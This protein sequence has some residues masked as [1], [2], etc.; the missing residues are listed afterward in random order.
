MSKLSLNFKT[1]NCAK[2]VIRFCIFAILISLV[3]GC[4]SAP[5][6]VGVALMELE[7]EDFINQQE[8]VIAN[9][10]IDIRNSS[11]DNRP[12]WTSTT[13]FEQGNSIYFTGTFVRGVD[14]SMTLRLANAEALKS[15]VQSVGTS[16]RA[17]FSM[18]AQG[19][20]DI[21]SGIDRY[22]EDGIATFS[23]NI[24]I[25]GI[26]QAESYYE[27]M[28]DPKNPMKPYYNVW[29]KLEIG[30]SEYLRAKARVLKQLKNDFQNAGETEAKE[31]AQILLNDLKE[32]VSEAI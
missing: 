21:E 1:H 12:D 15:M 17:E 26:R 32:Q 23:N 31:K 19:A 14:Y 20:N 5:K 29:V 9:Q 7:A 8:T 2:P 28:Y 6:K 22:V 3:M 11:T 27:E 30:K 13:V 16:I 24:H 10:P 4:S 18:F 25:Q